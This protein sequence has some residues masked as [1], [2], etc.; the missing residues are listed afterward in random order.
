MTIRGLTAA[1]EQ[2]VP[3]ADGECM[4]CHE[5]HGSDISGLLARAV[6]GICMDCHD[7]G[8]DG[9]AVADSIYR[10]LIELVALSDSASFVPGTRIRV[11]AGYAAQLA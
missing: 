11:E 5:V 10:H 2:A 9:Y 8:D 7:E 6:P 1:D 4:T 3:E